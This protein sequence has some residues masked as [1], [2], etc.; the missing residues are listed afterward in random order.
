MEEENLVYVEVYD[1][2]TDS[3]DNPYSGISFNVKAED[4]KSFLQIC[5]Y[6]KK[7]VNIIFNYTENTKN[8]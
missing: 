4:M 3:I 5:K 2:V 8:G 1:E 7:Y 6:N